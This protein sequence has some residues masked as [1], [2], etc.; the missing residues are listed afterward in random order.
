MRK[1]INSNSPLSQPSVNA[2]LLRIREAAMYLG[3]TVWQVRTLTWSKRLPALKLG[4]RY[5]YDRADLDAFVDRQK[6]EASV[7]R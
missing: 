2:R 7:P 6:L 5:V 3:S 4:N 1:R